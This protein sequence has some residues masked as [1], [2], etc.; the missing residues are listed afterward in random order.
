M[1]H[2]SSVRERRPQMNEMAFTIGFQVWDRQSE[3]TRECVGSGMSPTSLAVRFCWCESTTYEL[4]WDG[5]IELLRLMINIWKSIMN[6]SVKHIC[7]TPLGIVTRRCILMHTWS[8]NGESLHWRIKL[9]SQ[10]HQGYKA[11]IGTISSSIHQSQRVHKHTE[12]SY[13]IPIYIGGLLVRSY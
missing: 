13:Y 8:V 3:R 9:L 5:I 1:L 11:L 4:L 2:L 12:H 7:A 10:Q 6:L